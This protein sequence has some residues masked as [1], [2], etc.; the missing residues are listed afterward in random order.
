ML[1]SIDS[2]VLCKIET[3]LNVLQVNQGL[4]ASAVCH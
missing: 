1:M 2:Q 4:L 3:D